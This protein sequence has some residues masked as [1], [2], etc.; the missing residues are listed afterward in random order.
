MQ[1]P[2]R[3]TWRGQPPRWAPIHGWKPARA[4][5]LHQS[6]RETIDIGVLLPGKVH[7]CRAAMARMRR[8]P[9]LL[10]R[11]NADHRHVLTA[12]S[13][14]GV[15]R[16]DARGIAVPATEPEAGESS[17]A[18][19]KGTIQRSVVAICCLRL[20]DPGKQACPRAATHLICR[21]LPTI[22]MNSKDAASNDY[23]H[24]WPDGLMAST[25]V[26]YGLPGK[27]VPKAHHGCYSSPLANI[28]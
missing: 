14:D 21:S 8:S 9:L 23:C 20:M 26:V 13:Y 16:W 15:T 6:T 2:S 19:V 18:A 11:M 22:M 24:S 28:L 5:Q 3:R 25:C 17:T 27:H 4:C 10:S 12:A 1:G 7:A